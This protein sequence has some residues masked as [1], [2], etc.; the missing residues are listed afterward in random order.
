M[1]NE[2]YTFIPPALDY[3]YIELRA[4][5]LL[6]STQRE[7]GPVLLEKIKDEEWELVDRNMPSL[8]HPA[9]NYRYYGLK[10]ME[11]VGTDKNWKWKEIK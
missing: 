1:D 10:A 9:I 2:E 7:K 11:R 6:N 4:K 8:L 5:L 3:K